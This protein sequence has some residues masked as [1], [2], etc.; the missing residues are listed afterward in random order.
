M[1][2]S[3]KAAGRVVESLGIRHDQAVN[4]TSITRIEFTGLLR[5]RQVFVAG[6]K[7]FVTK[8]SPFTINEV[9]VTGSGVDS[10]IHACGEEKSN[11]PALL[12][13]LGR[14]MVENPRNYVVR[15]PQLH[16][17]N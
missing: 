14:D 10:F 9:V 5:R 8:A 11:L 2:M 16:I 7:M 15:L 1:P 13:E 12:K 3:A 17:F 6:G 4:D